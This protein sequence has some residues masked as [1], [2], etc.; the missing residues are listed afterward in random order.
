MR[1]I[2]LIPESIDVTNH[3]TEKLRLPFG[4]E[5]APGATTTVQLFKYTGGPSAGSGSNS[6]GTSNDPAKLDPQVPAATVVGAPEPGPLAGIS[7]G[8][9]APRAGYLTQTQ[10]GANTGPVHI[11]GDSPRQRLWNAIV[12][13]SQGGGASA[14]FVSTAIVAAGGTGYS[15]GDVLSVVG[16]IFG[17]AAT[18][19]VLTAPAG[20]V[21]TVAVTLGGTYTTAPASPAATAGG[22]GTGCTLTLTLAS[23]VIALGNQVVGVNQPNVPVGGGSY[24]GADLD[25]QTPGQKRATAVDTG[26]RVVGGATGFNAPPRGGAAVVGIIPR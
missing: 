14:Q 22:A 23:N 8:A 21:A 13:S 16:G 19:T 7:I 20:V 1:P 2:E 6:S 18:V 25:Y 3:G 4:I 26:V 24:F 10:A 9:G 17:V 15:A 12:A 5:I 11:A